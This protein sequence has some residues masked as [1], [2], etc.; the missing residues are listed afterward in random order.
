MQSKLKKEQSFS[1]TYQFLR[2]RKKEE[3]ESWFNNQQLQRYSA[4][5]DI[6]QLRQKRVAHD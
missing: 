2:I 6:E 4:A 5:S 1:V 3:K